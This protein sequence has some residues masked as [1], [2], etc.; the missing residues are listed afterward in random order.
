MLL[1]H[2]VVPEK[3]TNIIRNPFEGLTYRV[4]HEGQMTDAFQV[5]TGMRQRCLLSSFLF[6]LAIDW[7]MATSTAQKR[8]GIQWS[9]RTQLDDLNFTDDLTLL[10]FSQQQ[11]QKK[12]STVAENS[13][14]MGLN[15][16]ATQ[17]NH[18]HH[19]A[20]PQIEPPGK[21]EEGKATDHL[22]TPPGD[23]NQD[24]EMG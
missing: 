14:K 2:Y 16:D 8:N 19:K 10:S 1:R 20:G 6:L 12:T 4:V 15:I 5:K 17:A 23:R 21:K 24:D 3:L 9:F 22:A 18:Q 7:V 11:M 13:A